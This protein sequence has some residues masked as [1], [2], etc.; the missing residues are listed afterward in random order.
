MLNLVETNQKVEREGR[1]GRVLKGLAHVQVTLYRCGY[2]QCKSCR[3]ENV[4]VNNILIPC[5]HN[6]I[7]QECD[8]MITKCPFCFKGVT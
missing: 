5:F 6:G 3:M 7:C 1:E 2:G 8:K 4:Y